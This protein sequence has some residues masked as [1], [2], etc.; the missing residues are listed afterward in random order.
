MVNTVRC[1]VEV[2]TAMAGRAVAMDE[3]RRI[4]FRIGINIGDIIPDG[5]DIFGDGVNIA[6][7]LQE[8]AWI[9]PRMA[10]PGYEECALK[11]DMN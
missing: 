11:G 1:A 4:A 2:Q 10:D 5:D 7:R 8:I 3:D 9:I 6:A